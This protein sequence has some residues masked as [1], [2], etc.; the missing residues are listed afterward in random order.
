MFGLDTWSVICNASFSCFL[1]LLPVGQDLFEEGL[2]V[3]K[4]L[5]LFLAKVRG[6][7]VVCFCEIVELEGEGSFTSVVLSVPAI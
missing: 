1:P 7:L 3:P 5:V 4:T 6:Q 2:G